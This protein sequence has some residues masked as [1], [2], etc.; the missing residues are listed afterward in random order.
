MPAPELTAPPISLACSICS[1]EMKLVSINPT[2]ET[3]IYEYQCA[4][5]HRHKI[6]MADQYCPV[7]LR[8]LGQKANGGAAFQVTRGCL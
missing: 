1:D 5:G 7:N 3:T 4:N 8:G 2:S 6:V